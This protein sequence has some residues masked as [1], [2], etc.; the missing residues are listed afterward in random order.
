MRHIQSQIDN[1]RSI[2]IKSQKEIIKAQIEEA[3]NYVYH[4]KAQAEK[5]V[6]FKVK[7]RTNEAFQTALYI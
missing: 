4:K 6:K 3:V 1:T 7:S 2:Y 5:R